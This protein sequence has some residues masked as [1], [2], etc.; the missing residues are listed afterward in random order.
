MKKT[1]LISGVLL[2]LTASVAAAQPGVN[3]SW[4]DCGLAGLQN[5][6]FACNTNSGAPFIMY[7]SFDPP[8]DQQVAAGEWVIDLEAAGSDLPPWWH[9]KNAGACRVNS[10]VYN[11]NFAAGPFS[12][13]DMWAGTVG[14]AGYTYVVGHSGAN[15]ARIFGSMSVPATSPVPAFA[16]TETYDFSL[17]INR[18]NTVAPA[19]VCER[20]L[21]PVCVVLNEIK[22][23]NQVGATTV[24]SN[25]RDRNFVTWQGGAVQTPGCPLATPAQKSSWGQVKSLYR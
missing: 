23:F 3:L 24:I 2:A 22:L 10:L 7:A 9:F 12:C 1:L 21:E 5:A 4:N 8:A 17:I 13:Y 6:A 11:T 14:L 18:A 25:P 19:A 20:C 16:G 15:T